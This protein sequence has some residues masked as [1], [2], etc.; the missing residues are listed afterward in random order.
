MKLNLEEVRILL[1]V[2]ER[3]CQKAYISG[4]SS[5]K[6]LFDSLENLRSKGLVNTFTK[7]NKRGEKCCV[8]ELTFKGRF[9]AYAIHAKDPRIKVIG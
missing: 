8:P 3:Y 7:L 4:Y 9:L 6:Y 5:T 1:Y 2:R